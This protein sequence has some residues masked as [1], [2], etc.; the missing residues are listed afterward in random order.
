MKYSL[1][2]SVFFFFSLSL[3]GMKQ[4]SE[5]ESIVLGAGCFWCVEAIFDQMKGIESVESG[6]MGGSV[7]NPEYREVCSGNTGHAEVVKLIFDPELVSLK[8]ILEVFFQVHDPTTLNR[9]GADVG[10]QYRSVIFYASDAQK[11]TALAVK[12]QLTIAKIWKNPIVTEI[13][14]AVV[15]YKAE[16]YHQDYYNLNGDNPYCSAVITPKI[17][18]F[19][20]VFSDKLK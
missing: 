13:S 16:N 17:E 11:E 4:G 15:F 1:V 7:K 12:R 20:K 19:K 18:K 2:L 5:N 14:A 9:Q 10:T 3:F 6:Y 8:E